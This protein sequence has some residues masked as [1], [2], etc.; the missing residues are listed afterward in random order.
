MFNRSYLKLILQFLQ[1]WTLKIIK[2]D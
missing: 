1:E 2:S